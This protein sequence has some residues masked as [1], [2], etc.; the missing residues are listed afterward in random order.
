MKAWRLTGE[1]TV[2][3]TVGLV[4]DASADNPD[5]AP[6]QVVV[7]IHA[8]SINF[9]DLMLMRG[10][11]AIAA[12][13]GTIPLSDGAGEIVAVGDS[14][15]RFGVGDRVTTT[16]FQRWVD[17]TLTPDLAV[18]Q[19]GAS[20]DG[21]LAEQILCEED[22]LVRIPDPLSFEEAATLPCSALTAWSALTGPTPIA[23]GSTVLTLGSGGVALFAIQLAQ[24]FGARVIAATSSEE[25]AQRLRALGA[26]TVIDYRQVLRWHEAVLDTTDGRGVDRVVET[27]GPVTLDRSVRC[28]AFG[29]EIAHVGGGGFSEEAEVPFDSRVLHGRSLTLRRVT[30]GS[31]REFERMNRAIDLHRLHPV[32]DQVFNFDDAPLSYERIVNRDHVG[33]VVVRM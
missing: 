28:T 11:Y 33:K 6:G 23:P 31:R 10:D 30:V 18:E 32:I 27:V 17:G 9:R 19:F 22:S 25:K 5:P 16:Y 15:R 24:L 4:L 7:R 21:A 2:D 20:R 14:V 29:G 26:E 12:P 3:P 13:P 8:A 1:Y